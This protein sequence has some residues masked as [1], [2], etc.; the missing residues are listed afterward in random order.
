MSVRSFGKSR[1][2]RT[3]AGTAC[4]LGFAAFTARMV[5]KVRSG[6]GLEPYA[7]M[8]GYPAYPL[9]VLVFTVLA[10]TVAGLGVIL[11][12]WDPQAHHRSKR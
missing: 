12:W 2:V 3:I 5:M 11:K 10:L 6:Q 8:A 1:A 4:L 7:S 9:G